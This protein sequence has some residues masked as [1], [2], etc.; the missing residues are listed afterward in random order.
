MIAAIKRTTAKVLRR[1]A[2]WLWRS[3]ARRPGLADWAN[4]LDELADRLHPRPQVPIQHFDHVHGAW[5]NDGP[6]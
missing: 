1:G 2:S 4:R 6:R 3:I 5:F